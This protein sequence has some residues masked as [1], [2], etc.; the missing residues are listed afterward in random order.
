[1]QRHNQ[2][3][4]LINEIY[5]VLIQLKHVYKDNPYRTSTAGLCE[6]TDRFG[7]RKVSDEDCIVAGSQQWSVHV[8]NH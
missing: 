2:K 7:Q 4:T 6:L 3:C 5:V 8:S 1:M